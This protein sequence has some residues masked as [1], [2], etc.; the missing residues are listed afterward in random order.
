GTKPASWLVWVCVILFVVSGTSI[1]FISYSL[2]RHKKMVAALRVQLV[3]QKAELKHRETEKE[4]LRLQLKLKSLDKKSDVQEKERAALREQIDK[5]R[6]E[7]R[8]ER[9]SLSR[10]LKALDGK[11]FDSLLDQA[12][13]LEKET[14]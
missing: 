3:A 4:E 10:E 6:Q 9:A 12:K 14:L 11:K 2:A 8:Q 5:K 7:L 13:K 1:F